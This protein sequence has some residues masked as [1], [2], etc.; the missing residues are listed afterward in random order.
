MRTIA[1]TNQKGGSGKTTTTVNLAAALGEQ[2]HRV[3]VLDLDPQASATSWLGVAD[4]GKGLF[5]VFTE[6]GDLGS[7]VVDTPVQGVQL[8]PASAWMA[9]LERA[10]SSEVGTETILRAALA[11]LPD[12]WDFVLMDCPPS[13]SLLAVS[14]LTAADEVLVPVE[15][16][17]LALQGL[18]SLNKTIE[19]VR[20]RLNKQLVLGG[21]VVCRVR[22]TNLSREVIE[23]LVE[24]FGEA[25]YEAYVRNNVRLAEA[26]SFN[27][28][29]TVY[30]SASIGAK[31]YRAVAREFLQRQA[32]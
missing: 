28:P 1:I 31:D 23:M 21:I 32:V 22:N 12:R 8:V 5:Q 14:A 15:A 29:I 27:E 2:G 26:P 13:L 19:R 30:D 25:V 17:V 3:L 9:G 11:D 6:D 7:A 16:S 18:A 20:K 24:S 10:L 4:G